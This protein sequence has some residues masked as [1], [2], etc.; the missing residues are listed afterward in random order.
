MDKGGKSLLQAIQPNNKWLT[1]HHQV[2]EYTPA[3]KFIRHK[4]PGLPSLSGQTGKHT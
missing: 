2:K 3:E 1:L 4:T